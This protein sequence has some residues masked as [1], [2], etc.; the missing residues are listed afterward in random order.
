MTKIFD[1]E[2]LEIGLWNMTSRLIMNTIS[3]N[4]KEILRDTITI[5]FCGILVCILSD[6]FV[7]L[8]AF[9]QIDLGGKSMMKEM[10]FIA[11]MAST[12]QDIL[13]LASK[14][15]G[16]GLAFVGVKNAGQRNWD[17]AIPAFV[18]GSGLFFLPQ[19]VAALSKVGG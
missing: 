6:S 19:I 11:D 9:A 13:F 14:V 5:V 15:V 7:S 16:A 3:K 17:H 4:S 12:I 8:E 18:G 2:K 10:P 1:L